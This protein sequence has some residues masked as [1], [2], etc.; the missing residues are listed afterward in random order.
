MNR[1]IPRTQIL[2]SEGLPFAGHSAG[3]YEFAEL[4]RGVILRYVLPLTAI[5]VGTY[6]AVSLSVGTDVSPLAYVLLAVCGGALAMAGNGRHVAALRVF[7][8]SG[9]ALVTLLN[10]PGE[11]RPNGFAT[12]GCYLYCLYPMTWWFCFPG[13]RGR[14]A[15]LAF[16]IAAPCGIAALGQHPSSPVVVP[17]AII[18]LSLVR[19]LF[20]TAVTMAF[21]QAFEVAIR[22]FDDRW[23][24]HYATQEQLSLD[25]R[26]HARDLEREAK[27]HRE[28]LNHL[29]RSEV[30]LRY[31]FDHAFDGIAVFD[32]ERDRAREVNPRLA[33]LLGYSVEELLRL[34]PM[35][36]SP[37]VQPD[38]TTSLA[39]RDRLAAELSAHRS[40][41]H[42][43]THLHAA[44][45]EVDFE[46]TVFKL[47]G[48]DHLGMT[49]FRDVTERNR[50]T[51]ELEAANRELRTFAHA[52]SHD[53][54]EPLRTMANFA[55]LL[56]RRYA[57]A[58]GDDGREY[59]GFITDAARRGTTL[60][61]DLLAYA[62]VGT[63][64]IALRPTRLDPV[65]ATVRGNLAA[66]LAEAGAVL[67]IDALPSVLA[68]PTWAQQLL[69]NLISNA[70]K[71]ARA[72]VRPV[73][74]V[75][76]AS[77]AVGHTIR[78]EDNGIGI[79]AE[80]LDRVFGVFQRLVR[81]E[82]YEGNGIGLALCR[83]IT[84]RLGGDISVRSTLGSGTTFTI[85]LPPCPQSS[86]TA[87]Q[88]PVAS[89]TQ[90][91]ARAATS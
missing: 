75:T 35:E 70:L 20:F 32:F 44:G 58:V 50:A 61:Q 48:E 24:D 36:I 14:L 64:E 73:V 53:L 79:A 7:L 43:W 19:S 30:R 46:V 77:D 22:R 47:P 74:R 15:V 68:T 65:A 38:G 69:Q 62:E 17:D 13:R 12:A 10:L 21:C 25:L 5:F 78:V 60:V 37:A 66:R 4:F 31:L 56:G 59:I 84:E 9:L 8:L 23:R 63:S 52:A 76:C 27:A 89:R 90:R 3:T 39:A 40:V 83:R 71:F 29:S 55:D 91:R 11:G 51:R 33:E 80:D 82:D 72:G 42:A 88:A 16:C 28:T 26:N 2:A 67:E 18:A 87:R 1:P 57:E 81:R 86:A 34:S 49:L 85:W 54:K 6:M 41:T 45:H